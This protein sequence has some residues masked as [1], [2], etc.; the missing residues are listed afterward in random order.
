MCSVHAKPVN[1]K[2]QS[3]LTTPNDNIHATLPESLKATE[4]RLEAKLDAKLDATVKAIQESIQPI[5]QKKL[6]LNK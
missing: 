2:C 5:Q 4:N 3:N 1:H 6:Q